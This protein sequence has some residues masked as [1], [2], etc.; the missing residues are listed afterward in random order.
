MLTEL[1]LSFLRML[2]AYI[3]SLGIA[4]SLGYI[5]A[6]DKIMEKIFMPFVDV[7]QSVPILTFFPIALYLIIRMVPYGLGPEIAVI[8]LIVTSMVWNL[9]FAVYESMLSL[10]SSLKEIIKMFKLDAINRFFM[11]YVPNS[12]RSVIPNSMVSWAN[13]WYFLIATEIISIGSEEYKLRGI[14]SFLMEN[15]S[16]GNLNVVFMGIAAVTLLIVAMNQLIWRPLITI[17]DQFYVKKKEFNIYMFIAS[18]LGFKKSS[19]FILNLISTMYSSFVKLIKRM[20]MKYVEDIEGFAIQLIG[21]I[22]AIL[23]VSFL[24]FSLWFIEVSIEIVKDVGNEVFDVAVAFLFSFLRILIALLLSLAWTLPVVYLMTK[25]KTLENILLPIFEVVAAIPV[26]ALFPVVV[27]LL[28]NAFPL[29][30]VVLIFLMTGMQW[31]I[32][33][34]VYGGLK[35]IP[36][37]FYDLKVLFRIPERKFL[38]K[39]VLPVVLPLL[40]VGMMSAVGGGW[41][42]VIVAEYIPTSENIASVNGIGSLMSYG[43]KEG[44]LG[45]VYLTAL[46]V[47]ITVPLINI[48][49][50]RPLL[51]KAGKRKGAGWTQL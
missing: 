9:I 51:K 20:L 1:L 29:E 5:L 36:K 2:I 40:I 18:R 3:I 43:L 26:T 35:T 48:F 47:G 21:G 13:G 8:F 25:S 45:L 7:L 12:L 39:I 30:I 32:L 17:L 27:I 28:I 38:K 19:T 22:K 14:G 33:F 24:I 23:L 31:Y 10:P 15:A 37:E 49:V 41:N 44:N 11:I 50:W 16:K 34:N 4:Y 42:A 6:K 46:S